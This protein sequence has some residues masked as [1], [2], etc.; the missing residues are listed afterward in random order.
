MRVEE[1]YFIQAEA[2]AHMNPMQGLSL[3]S[4]FMKTYRDPNYSCKAASTDALVEE[5]VFQKRVELWGEGQSFFDIKRLNMSVTRAYEGSNF[6][7]NS[8]MNTVGRPAW[9]NFVILKFEGD[10]N[11]AVTQW[12]NPDTD[13]CYP[14][15]EI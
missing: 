12:N 15:I 2:A 4:S 3:I 7:G 11:S 14:V 6:S 8:L 13:G 1:M 5:I 9:M 10:N